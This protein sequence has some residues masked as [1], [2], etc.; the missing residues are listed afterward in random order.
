MSSV[1]E[2]AGPI[3]VRQVPSAHAY[4]E[5]L[6]PV[7]G[8]A[9]VVHLP[10]PP[11]PGAPP[12]QWWPH[13]ALA[14]DWVHEHVEEQD[15][16]HVHFGTEGRTLAQLTEWLGALRSLGLPLVHTVHDIDHPHL[17]D[18]APHREQLALLVAEADGL[19]TLTEGAAAVVEREH[20][21]RP[22]VVPH[23]HIAPLE[24][25]GRRLEREASVPLRV[26]LH[27][28]SLRTNLAP[29]RVLPALVE[30]VAELRA[31]GIEVELEVRAHPDLLGKD[32]EGH[33]EIWWRSVEQDAPA[34]VHLLV[35][36]RLG[37]DALWD[38]LEGLDV[39]VL[40][41]AWGTHSGWVEACRDLGTW[42]LAPEVGHLLEQ[43]AGSVLTWGD[44]DASPAAATLVHL[45]GRAAG[46]PPPPVTAAWRRAQREQIAATHAQVYAAV[47]AG[48][49]L[50][51]SLG[52]DAS[53]EERV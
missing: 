3:R 28:K 5:N 29:M 42:V 38:Y 48:H 13:P 33:A 27:L 37:D 31:A 53:L 7:D 43:G 26:G 46:S 24:R 35:A 47:T 11:V 25:I 39:S 49:R 1:P 36:P 9:T 20:G 34:G 10:D 16:L 4:V 15:V 32:T 19:L 51:A 23:P 40:P 2:G 22:L 12:G 41:Y 30:A 44:P 18:Q 45:L 17:V 6:L 21:R 8:S 14:A 50:D 52:G